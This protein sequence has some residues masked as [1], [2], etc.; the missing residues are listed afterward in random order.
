MEWWSISVTTCTVSSFLSSKI[1][2]PRYQGNSIPLIRFSFSFSFPYSLSLSDKLRLIV[3]CK[4]SSLPFLAPFPFPFSFPFPFPFLSPSNRELRIPWADTCKTHR[5]RLRW[6]GKVVFEGWWHGSLCS[7]P[8]PPYLLPFPLPLLSP[9][10]L[11]LI[12][13]TNWL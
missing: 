4:Y 5:Q 9:A 1:K 10:T 11:Y 8:L 2:P 6:R 7:P 13:S 12:T 3:C